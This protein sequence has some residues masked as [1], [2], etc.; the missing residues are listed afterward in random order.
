MALLDQLVQQKEAIVVAH[1]NYQQRKS[2][3]RDEK[4]VKAYCARWDLPCFVLYPSYEGKKNFQAWAR[5]VRYDFFEKIMK[6]EGIHDLYVAHHMDDLIETYIFQKQRGMLCDHFG[7]APLS[8]RAN[9]TI[10]RPLLAYE[11]KD[12]EKYCQVHHLLYG[13]D[14]SN[15]TNHYTRNRIRHTMIENLS[16]AEKEHI[17]EKI[18]LENQELKAKRERIL[19]QIKE[20][21]IVSFLD[22]EEGWFALDL[23][24]TPFL[25]RHLSKAHLISLCDQ[26]QHPCLIDLS[27]HEIERWQNTL[28][29]VPKRVYPSFTFETLDQ[30]Q[31]FEPLK[32]THFQYAFSK[33]GMKIESLSVPET[34]FPLTF[35]PARSQDAILLRWG[36]KK[37]QRFWIDRKIPKVWRKEWYVLENRQGQLIFVPG[38]GCE[39]GHFSIQPNAFMVQWTI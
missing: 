19:K 34:D 21:G 25:H 23:Y 33:S 4:I 27:T 22:Q 31:A 17:V 1:V 7:L 12:L 2:A 14:E 28:L 26:L 3:W 6:Q 8:Y 35:R 15:L 32:L 10:H 5:Q 30:L 39:R 20:Q 9:Y 11:K 38:I 37:M 13:I 16:K 36:T 24:L 18:E 29:V